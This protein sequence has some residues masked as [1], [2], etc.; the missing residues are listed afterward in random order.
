MSR[1]A[2]VS[3]TRQVH[4][5]EPDGRMSGLTTDADGLIWASWVSAGNPKFAHTWP[6]FSPSGD[7]VACFRLR[8]GGNASVL[9]T[10]LDGVRSAEVID[11]PDQVPIYLQWAEDGERIAAVTQSG[12]DLL[13]TIGR[14]ESVNSQ[15]ILAKGSPLFITWTQD[16]RLATFI[17]GGSANARMMIMD[18]D[19]RRPTEVLPGTPGDF[20]APVRAGDGVVYGVHAHGRAEI[21]RMG[22]DGSEKHFAGGEGLLAFVASPDGRMIAKAVAPGGDGTPYQ[23]LAVIDIETG[24]ERTISDMSCLAF[25]WTPDGSGLVV[26]RVDT[27][28]GLVEWFFVDTHGTARH[29]ADLLPTRDFRFFL[30]FFEQYTQSHPIVD[31][32]SRYLLLAGVLRG[33]AQSPRIWKCPLHG[34]K[35]IDIGEGQFATFSPPI[36]N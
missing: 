26:S 11:L 27:D 33:Q 22:T 28:R 32:D 29:V 14:T 16:G 15:R 5:V 8:E 3:P 6:S 36:A 9:V 18:P 10:S 24:V 23:G 19:M 13:L 34:G 31:P 12:D 25:V 20:C 35:P 1:I 7:R 17:G 21:V 4:L 2:F 30:R